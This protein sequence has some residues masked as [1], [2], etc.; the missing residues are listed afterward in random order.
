MNTE[1]TPE[2]WEVRM[3]D[4]EVEN[5]NVKGARDQA[6][7]WKQQRDELLAALRKCE[8]RLA[9]SVEKHFT[10]YV[11][12]KELLAEVRIAIAKCK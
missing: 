9:T 4:E 2:P 8:E 6:D 10:G 1:H 5:L 12:D 3:D 11:G 7:G